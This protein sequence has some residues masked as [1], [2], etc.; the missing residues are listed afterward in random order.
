MKGVI[1]D[2]GSEYIIV[3]TKSGDFKKIPN[4]VGQCLI[5]GEIEV[6][7][8]VPAMHLLPRRLLSLASTKR[9]AAAAIVFI[10]LLGLGGYAI[11]DYFNPV[12]FVTMDINPSIELALNRY[13]RVLAVDAFDDEGS[14]LAKDAGALKNMKISEALGILIQK[15]LSRDYLKE[16]GTI[17]LTVSGRQNR[18]TEN[19]N[20]KIKEFIREKYGNVQGETGGNQDKALRAQN[21]SQQNDR[22]N[23]ID[24]D[25]AQVHIIVENT[26]IEQHEKARKMKISQGKL[27]MYEKLQNLNPAVSLEDVKNAS[28]SSIIEELKKSK[29]RPPANEKKGQESEPKGTVGGH[30]DNSIN[31]NKNKE[32]KK[33]EDVKSEQNSIN[34]NSRNSD[35]DDSENKSRST[36]QYDGK[37]PSGEKSNTEGKKNKQNGKTSDNSG[38]EAESASEKIM[39]GTSESFAK[40]GDASKSPQKSGKN[41]K[42]KKG[43]NEAD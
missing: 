16:S 39:G 38:T 35:K 34:E 6:P 7:D 12:A 37:E 23:K 17:M 20:G 27:L 19:V 18:V 40:T 8:G 36:K 14:I 30:S 42:S 26:S 28:I 24:K 4:H 31:N 15:A 1:V 21:G 22:E 13:E 32:T 10:M 3:L 11:A 43:K 29:E 33:S 25:K 9:V 2:V 5:G 41:G